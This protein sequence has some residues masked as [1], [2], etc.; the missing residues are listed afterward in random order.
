MS[1]KA[2]SGQQDD[3]LYPPRVVV[4]FVETAQVPGHS[5]ARQASGPAR[6]S[7]GS[8]PDLALTPVFGTSQV[9]SAAAARAKSLD[10]TYKPVD[11]GVFQYVDAPPGTDLRALVQALLA[12]PE[13]RSANIDRG[14]PDPHVQPIDDPR[15]ANQGYLDAAPGG[16]DARFAWTMP[17]GDGAGQRLIDLERGWTLD[18]EDLAAHN[19]TLLHGSLENA[20]RDHGTPVLGIICAVDNALGCLGIVPNIASVDVVSYHGSDN[21]RA[22]AIKEAIDHLSFGDVLLLEAQVFVN[23]SGL[24]GPIEANDAEFEAIKLATAS[25]I[26]VVEAGGN[27]NNGSAPALDMDSFTNSSRKAIL[28]RDPNN[29]DFKESGAIMVSDASSAAPHTRLAFAPHGKRIDCYAWGE[30]IVAPDSDPMGNRTLYRTN[31]GG[32]SGASAI[33]AGAALAVQGIVEAHCNRVFRQHG[34]GRCSAAP[35]PALRP[36]R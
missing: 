28:H 36:L 18:H 34:C 17:G 35:S 32:T 12:R 16:I 14:A 22:K 27:G 23:D 29:R 4:R 3:V 2:D 7:L 8:F 31:F 6:L 26:I 24:Q 20:S 19:A 5:A 33:I 30:N 9:R 11:F 15:A 10:P 13:V 1:I 25:G 21:S